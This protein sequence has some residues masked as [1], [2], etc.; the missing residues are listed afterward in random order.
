MNPNLPIEQISGIG[1]YTVYK[2]KRLEIKTLADL[3]YHF[4]F[5][6]EDFSYNTQTSNLINGQKVTLKG[7]IWTIKNIRAKS[8]KFLTLA[9]LADSSGV[10]NIVWFNQPYIIKT[11]KPGTYVS[12]SGKVQIEYKKPKLLS[13]TYEILRERTQLPQTLHTGRLVPIYP[14]TEGL[15]SKWLRSKI[16]SILPRYTAEVTDF[17]PKEVSKRQNL[18][19]LNQA[20]TKIHFPKSIED[21]NAARRRLSFDE[22]FTLQLAAAQ[23]RK[24]WQKERR[25]YKFTVEKTKFEEFLKNLPFALTSAQQRAVA[26][27][28]KDLQR[29]T[30]A[31]RLLEGD[32][33]S[34]KTVVAA[35]AAYFA[36]Q[37]NMLTLL[38]AP[39]EILA[40]QHQKTLEELLRPHNIK[41]GIWTAA[42]KEDGDIVCGTHALLI[43]FKPKREVG[44]VVVDEQHRFGVAQRGKLASSDKQGKSPHILTMT[45]T[46]IPRTLALT[47][48]GDLDLSVLDE[49]PIGRQKI[50]TH[51]VP[52]FKR[53]AAYKFIEDQVREN[54]QAF[55]I[56]PFVEPSE[57]MATVKAAVDEFEKLK[58]IFSNRAN[59]GKIKLGLLHGRLKSKDK[60]QVMA[61][62][63]KKKFDILVA[64]PVVEVGIDIPN[65]TVMMIESA[66]RFGLAQLHQ[67]RGRVGRGKHKSY[68]LLFTD[69]NSV[70]SLKRLKSMENIYIGFELA[71]LDLKTRGPGEIFG[72]K[73]SGYVNLK[74]ADISN[75]VLVAQTQK[76]AQLIIDKDP[77]LKEFKNLSQKLK[78]LKQDYIQPN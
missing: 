60:Q 64:T 66:D 15:T 3:I 40:Y 30:P 62:F 13:P 50:Q 72:L 27:I 4:P 9:T 57:S 55:I 67:L 17:L 36:H 52:N 68:C 54:R 78:S 31:N 25:A 23:R 11:L 41:I 48:Y 20:L 69:S 56:T 7:N 53:S 12:V 19:N 5:R 76:E 75:Q 63:K 77:S 22:L 42:K 46:P 51:V 24:K 74:I 16:A 8:G 65:A 47:L 61:D 26:E 38:A 2:L 59:T 14:E 70:N 6:Y 45:A 29:E 71:E 28:L 21:V 33:G 34:G 49:M 37:N 1:K 44:L 73:Q 58:E 32:V 10:V 18:I 35:T 43:S 39:T